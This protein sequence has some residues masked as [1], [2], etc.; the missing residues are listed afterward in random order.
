MRS[1]AQSRDRQ[2]AVRTKL[3]SARVAEGGDEI[4]NILLILHAGLVHNAVADLTLRKSLRSEWLYEKHR[5]VVGHAVERH[6]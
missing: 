6:R 2:G 1:S 5:V 3:L 4:D